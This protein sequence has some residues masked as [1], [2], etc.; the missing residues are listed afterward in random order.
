MTL[1]KFS[2]EVVPESM[3]ERVNKFYARARIKNRDC[4]WYTEENNKCS[5]MPLYGHRPQNFGRTAVFLYG[6][7][8]LSFYFYCENSSNLRTDKKLCYLSELYMGNKHFGV[9]FSM[10]DND[11]MEMLKAILQGFYGPYC[12]PSDEVIEFDSDVMEI[13][14]GYSIHDDG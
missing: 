11:G 4:T 13:E 12:C 5:F 7:N 9:D 3:V 6:K 14:Y 10:I 8:L 1:Y 2:K